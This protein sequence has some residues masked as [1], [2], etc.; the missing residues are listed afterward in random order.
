MMPTTRSDYHPFFPQPDNLDTPVW[1]YMD[2]GSLVAILLHNELPLVRVDQFPDEFEGTFP[3]LAVDKFVDWLR[4][5]GVASDADIELHMKNFRVWSPA[6]RKTTFVS[7]WRLDD[8]E[9]EAMWRIYCKTD[10][11]VAIVLP[12]RHLFSAAPYPSTL[13]GLVTYMNYRAESFEPG[14]QF[15][16]VMHKRLEFSYE[17][18]VRIARYVPSIEKGEYVEPPAG[19]PLVVQM[20][21]DSM[22]IQKIVVSPYARSW[23]TETVREAV[24]RIAPGVGSRVMESAMR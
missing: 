13:V 5:G 12:Y 20:P 11:G 19:S 9:S 16:L 3:R 7:C 18:E 1:R 6:A 10:S 23:F 15:S 17:A 4:R 2:F 14:N 21:F 24:Q 8:H 22:L